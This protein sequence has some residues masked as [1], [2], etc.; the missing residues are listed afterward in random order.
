MYSLNAGAST[1]NL[2]GRSQADLAMRCQKTVHD[3]LVSLFHLH[4]VT[5]ARLDWP[6]HRGYSIHRVHRWLNIRFHTSK[7]GGTRF[8]NSA[9]RWLSGSCSNADIFVSSSPLLHG[10]RAPWFGWQSLSSECVFF[11]I[12]VVAND[13]FH[14]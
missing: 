12:T 5:I 1:D 2:L 10:G 6:D 11:S 8:G 4:S 9:A 7:V 14:R 13:R 3:L